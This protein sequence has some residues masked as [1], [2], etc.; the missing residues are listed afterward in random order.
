MKNFLIKHDFEKAIV[1]LFISS[2]II[3]GVSAYFVYNQAWIGPAYL[4]LALL[5]II[6]LKILRINL[7][8]VYPDIIFGIIDNGIL[9]FAAIVGANFAGVQGAVIG[10]VAG[11][12]ITDA[13][14]GLIEGKISQKL[15]H[16]NITEKR[17]PMSTM[18]GKMIGCLIGGGAGLGI[19]WI[20]SFSQL[21][22]FG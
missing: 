9:V 1:S 11:N 4:A 5:L 22:F 2:I 17:H 12:T 19:L 8:S 7:K 20:I 15:R 21:V 10:G 3:I 6:F 13:I 16:S 18:L 14:G